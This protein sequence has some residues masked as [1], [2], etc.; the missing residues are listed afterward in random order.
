MHPYGSEF[1]RNTQEGS[2]RS[3][4]RVLP[5]LIELAAPR[6][7]VD[8]G[9]G[10][11][12]WLKAAAELGVADIAGIDGAYVDRTM[13]QIPPD[14]FTAV[15]L[16]NPFHVARTYDVALSLEVAEHLPESSADAFVESLTR[17]APIVMFSAAIPNQ[18]GAHHVNEQWPGWWI[19][20]FARYGYT[21]LDIIRPRIWDDPQVEWWYAQ[22]TLLMVRA[23][24]LGASDRLRRAQAVAVGPRDVVHPRAYLDRLAAAEQRRPRGPVEWLALGPEIASTTLRRWLR[25]ADKV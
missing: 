11:G 21:A 5:H 20:R 3:A 15:D 12:T 24:V 16:T 2:L 13:L 23:D 25:R 14:R 6:S 8:V 18:M 1:Y 19:E 17:L 9:C 7:I 22:N 4:R 10:V